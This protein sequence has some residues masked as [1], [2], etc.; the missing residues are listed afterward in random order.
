[1]AALWDVRYAIRHRY[2]SPLYRKLAEK[3]V[4]DDGFPLSGTSPA[5]DVEPLLVVLE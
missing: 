4:Q 3:H 1:M 2:V 5:Y